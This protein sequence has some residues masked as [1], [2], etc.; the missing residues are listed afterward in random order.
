MVPG[1]VQHLLPQLADGGMVVRES[2][3]NVTPV[4]GHLGT[5]RGV[6]SE[7]SSSISVLLSRL[8]VAAPM[9]PLVN[10]LDGR[11]RCL[12]Q[13]LGTRVGRIHYCR[14]GGGAGADLFPVESAA[15]T[16][17]APQTLIDGA[18]QLAE[19]NDFSALA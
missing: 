14:G 10:F 13:R 6:A 12:A 11:S 2:V 18:R 3:M 17:L 7:A 19:S 1:R 15:G 8:C 9:H 4:H 16:G 5:S